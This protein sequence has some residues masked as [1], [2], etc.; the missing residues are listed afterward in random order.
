MLTKDRIIELLKAERPR[1]A[2]EFG[3]SKIGLFGSYAHG[4]PRQDSD[5]DLLVEF[6]RPVGLQFVELA[7]YLESVLG[8]RVDILTP[9]GLENIRIKRVAEGIAESV[10]YV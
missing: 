4:I 3:V 1:L 6:K 8:K 5:I 9:A 7:D 10:V 2:A